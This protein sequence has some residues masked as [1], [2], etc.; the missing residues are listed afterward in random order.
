MRDSA[1]L[2]AA[3]HESTESAPE[4]FRVELAPDILLPVQF[5]TGSRSD[6]SLCPEKRLMLA[7]LENAFA[8]FQ[9]S[10]AA[11]GRESLRLFREAESWFESEDTVWRYSFTNICQA[12][13]F[14]VTYVQAGLRRWRDAQRARA[15]RG[16]AGIRV[17]PRRVTGI[18]SKVAGRALRGRV[19]SR[20]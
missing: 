9:R 18:H 1:S 11:P 12:L 14:E 7:V 15:L 4:K 6:A 10:V 3:V 16:E 2:A 5:N 8:D 13:G 19:R 20:G 17:Q